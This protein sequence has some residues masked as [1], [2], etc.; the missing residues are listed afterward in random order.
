MSNGALQLAVRHVRRGEELVA[1]QRR[2]VER[3][4]SQG[5][6]AAAEKAGQLLQIL[7]QSLELHRRSLDRLRCEHGLD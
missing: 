4:E 3:L 1:D 7:E 2:R 5:E 6:M